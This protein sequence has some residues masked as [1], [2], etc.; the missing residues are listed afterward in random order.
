MKKKLGEWLFLLIKRQEIKFI[1][2]SRPFLGHMRQIQTATAVNNRGINGS[3]FI[4]TL[5]YKT[6]KLSSLCYKSIPLCDTLTP[7]ASLRLV[8]HRE[9]AA[10]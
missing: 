8:T 5:S 3:P 9:A 1:N 2:G 6:V 4:T 7:P 10:L